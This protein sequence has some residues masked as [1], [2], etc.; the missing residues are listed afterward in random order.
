MVRPCPVD[1]HRH[2][3]RRLGRGLDAHARQPPAQRAAERD[4]H[5]RAHAARRPANSD[6]ARHAGYRD[7]RH[8]VR[9]YAPRTRRVRA[10]PSRPACA[11]DERGR[12]LRKGAGRRRPDHERAGR[13]SA[14]SR[15]RATPGQGRPARRRA[16][17]RRTRS[18]GCRS[19]ICAN[20]TI[21]RHA[22]R[23]RLAAVRRTRRRHDP[24]C[25]TAGPRSA[26]PA[27]ARLARTASRRRRLPRTRL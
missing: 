10:V 9:Q 5:P 8:Q 12:D 11:A 21:W 20:A 1:P 13:R 4:R 3:D 2:V 16:R 22:R 19:P 17:R 7:R 27:L 24:S 14:R 6:G 18:S 23:G 26:P 15:R 25:A